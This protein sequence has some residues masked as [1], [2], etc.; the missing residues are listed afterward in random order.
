[1]GSRERRAIGS[2]ILGHCSKPCG[3]T[4]RF[5]PGAAT[6]ERGSR[7]TIKLGRLRHNL[8]TASLRGMRFAMANAHY[9]SS[10]VGSRSSLSLCSPPSCITT[11]T[12]CVIWIFCILHSFQVANIKVFMIANSCHLF[13][14]LHEIL[15]SFPLC[16]APS[17]VSKD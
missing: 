3:P 2:R 10:E 15:F 11:I 4:R 8:F 16:H 14:T 6:E 9:D 5:F 1:M 13:C 7:A 12:E 17:S